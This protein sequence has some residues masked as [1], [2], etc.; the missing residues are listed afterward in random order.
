VST[1]AGVIVGS[2][3]VLLSSTSAWSIQPSIANYPDSWT[4]RLFPFYLYC[5]NLFSVNEISW[6]G[7]QSFGID[8]VDSVVPSTALSG[9]NYRLALHIGCYTG[10]FTGRHYIY[11]Y[12]NGVSIGTFT[13]RNY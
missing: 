2:V 8:Q 9:F 5:V 11:I 6:V 10:Q 1:S 13:V 4:T 12:Y 3:D 7:D